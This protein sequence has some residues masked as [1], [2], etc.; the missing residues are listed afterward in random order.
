MEALGCI[1]YDFGREASNLIV[2][3]KFII[4]TTEKFFS[5]VYHSTFEIHFTLQKKYCTR[6][7]EFTSI[8]SN[9]IIDHMENL[10]RPILFA[11]VLSF[12]ILF[13]HV[14]FFL[15]RDTFD[16]VQNLLTRRV[17]NCIDRLFKSFFAQ[18]TLF[19]KHL[20]HNKIH[21]LIKRKTFWNLLD[22]YFSYGFLFKSFDN[23]FINNCSSHFR[24]FYKVWAD[25]VYQLFLALFFVQYLNILSIQ[26]L[27]DL[28]EL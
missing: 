6:S 17:L 16:S 15:S 26:I 4:E 10:L 2:L 12:N 28:F 13:Q 8:A 27:F 23:F 18:I 5:S 1:V 22:I 9:I 21:L 3:Y 24:P 25:F 19:I 7:F 20:I 11:L 14:R